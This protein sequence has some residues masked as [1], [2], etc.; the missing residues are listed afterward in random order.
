MNCIKCG[1]GIPDAAPYCC[2]CGKKQTQDPRK[3]LK[4]PNGAGS[5]YKLPGR[6]SRPWA[7]VKNK[8]I[9]GYY[10]KKSEALDALARLAG[11]DI[12]DR[13][14]MSFCAVYNGWKFEHY[15]DIGQKSIAA[16]ENSYKNCEFLY[17]RRFRDLRTRDFQE[18]IDLHKGKSRSAQAKYKHLFM[19]MSEWAM[20]EEIITTNYAKYVK[21]SGEKAKEKEIFTAEDIAKLEADGSPAAKIVLMLLYTGMRIGELFTAE[22]ANYHGDFLIG[23]EKTKAGRNRIIPIRPEGRAYFAELAVAATGDLLISGREGQKTAENYRKREYYPLLKRL[24]I[25]KK[26]PHAT[27]HTYAS[28]AI[29]SG[30]KPEI[31]QRILGHANYSTTTDTYYH[32]DTD[33]LVRAVELVSN[34]LVTD[35]EHDGTPQNV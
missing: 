7:A 33:E 34:L 1:K 31:L 8:L 23:G 35:E 21:L 30:I 18:V 29:A 17:E 16:Y 4:R 3:A 28:W 22:K 13:Y 2:W 5:V 11:E 27:R 12:S 6:R 24:G 19:Q 14:N 20:R 10:A 25:E 9:I 32:P 15:R 26:T